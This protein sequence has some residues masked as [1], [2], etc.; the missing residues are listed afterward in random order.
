[1]AWRFFGGPE[2]AVR[3]NLDLHF[4]V[5]V[6]TEDSQSVVGALKVVIEG[7]YCRILGSMLSQSIMRAG[8]HTRAASC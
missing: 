1:M 8:A 5:D 2:T 6:T 4:D 7:E 3:L